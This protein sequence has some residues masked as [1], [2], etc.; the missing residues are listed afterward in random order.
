MFFDSTH[1]FMTFIFNRF[2]IIMETKTS[3]G[4]DVEL[5]QSLKPTVFLSVSVPVI[6]FNYLWPFKFSSLLKS[7]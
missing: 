2:S 4:V 1:V 3:Y 5:R 6:I 7:K